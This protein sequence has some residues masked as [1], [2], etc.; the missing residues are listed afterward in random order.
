VTP[1]ASTLLH[2]RI[3][4]RGYIIVTSILAV[5]GQQ[6][7]LHQPIEVA[8]GYLIILFNMLVL[9]MTGQLLIH[10]NHAI[11][12]GVV[13]GL[14]LIAGQLSGTPPN[15]VFSQVVGI[16]VMSVYFF[17]VLTTAGM[18]LYRWMEIYSKFAFAV[19][20]IGFVLFAVNRVTGGDPRLTSVY[21]EPS[22]YISVTLPAIGFYVNEYLRRRAYGLECLIFLLSYALAD[23]SGGFIGL[24]LVAFFA[25]KRYIKGW[26][27]FASGTAVVLAV[28]GLYFGSQNVRLRVDDTA[29]SL[30]TADITNANGSTYAMLSNLYG[31]AKAFNDY[32]IAGVGIGGYQYVYMRYV[33]NVLVR[34][35]E[36]FG[37]NQF[38]ANSLYFRIA[39]ELGLFGLFFLLLFLVGCAQVRGDKHIVLRNALLPYLLE[40]LYHSGAYF[41]TELYFF[42]GIYLLNFLES[43]AEQKMA[44][45]KLSHP[46]A[47]EAVKN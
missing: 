42:S 36:Q 6:Y 11:F 31:A 38:D 17:S 24:L 40:R 2:H 10:R 22:I 28:L 43:R 4:L 26:K 18:E 45:S 44:A 20:L 14:G 46:Q 37:L 13:T 39:A 35:S 12:L 19:A 5:L 1:T 21:S 16:G 3:D 7:I 8:S 15:A 25:I 9:L 33:G 41:T 29:Y 30:M 47:G 27:L 32:P 34:R 23:S